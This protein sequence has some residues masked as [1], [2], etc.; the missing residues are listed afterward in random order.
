MDTSFY[1]NNKYVKHSLKAVGE[2]KNDK[3]GGPFIS[4]SWLNSKKT[5]S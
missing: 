3:M 4:Y 2:W 1:I 5:K